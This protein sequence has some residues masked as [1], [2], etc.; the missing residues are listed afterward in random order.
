MTARTDLIE[1]LLGDDPRPHAVERAE[2]LVNAYRDELRAEELHDPRNQ[3]E[4]AMVIRREA[5]INPSWLAEFIRQWERR[6]GG[7]Y[8]R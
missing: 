8:F 7:P 4:V 6:S 2:Q 3:V 1:A 5:R